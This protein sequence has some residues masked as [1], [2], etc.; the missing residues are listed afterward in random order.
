MPKLAGIGALVLVVAS[1]SSVR[2]RAAMAPIPATFDVIWSFRV[3]SADNNA[4]SGRN[5][6]PCARGGPLMKRYSD[7]FFFFIPLGLEL[8]DKKVYE[9]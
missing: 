9:P 6:S 8:S 3:L 7:F 4:N 2:F 1:S 5:W